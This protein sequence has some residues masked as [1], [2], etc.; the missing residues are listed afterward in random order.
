MDEPI[1]RDPNTE[2]FKRTLIYYDT[3]IQ[4]AHFRGNPLRQATKRHLNNSYPVKICVCVCVCVC[5]RV[6]VR[7]CM[8]VLD[9]DGSWV[10]ASKALEVVWTAVYLTSY[11]DYLTSY[12]EPLSPSYSCHTSL[13]NV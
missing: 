8:C 9:R 2:R 12:C 4:Y 6:C 1:P 11:S 7:A 5:V 3:E 10:F 13:K